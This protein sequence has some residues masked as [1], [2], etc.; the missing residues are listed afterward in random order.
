[1]DILTLILK[2]IENNEIRRVATNPL[3]QMGMRGRRLLGLQLMP[4]RNVPENMYEETKISYRTIVANDGTRYSPV[5]LKGGVK[6]GSFDVKLAES[7][8]GSE[9][10]A[11]D[12]DALLKML[13]RYQSSDMPMEAMVRVL[14][15]IDKTLNMPLIIKNE[16]MIWEAIVDAKV[17]RR[18][19]G[20]YKETINYSDPLGHRVSA[21]GDWSDDSYDPLEDIYTQ[22]QVLADKGYT[23]NRQIAGTSVI[24]KLLRNAKV[25]EAVGGY[26]SVSG[27]GALVAANGR[28]TLNALNE[29][30]GENELPVIERYDLQYQDQEGSKHYL[31]RDAFVQIATTG[32]DEEIDLGDE[33]PL[34]IQDTIGYTGVGTP[35]GQSRSGRNIR[36][37][38]FDNKPPRIEGESWQT[39]LPVPTEPEAISV[40]K[41]IQ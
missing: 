14:G 3:A 34:I 13:R 15:W 2:L 22:S 32:R 35:A 38:A 33:E 10:K 16:K 11:Q 18:G 40:I 1:M 37:E 41:E 21:L 20:G 24:T 12:Y 29:Y 31:K 25:K 30:L 36:V 6:V 19:D 7:D 23:V 39:S 8:T 27:G 4:E 26:I 9:F 5:Q 28:V 17:E